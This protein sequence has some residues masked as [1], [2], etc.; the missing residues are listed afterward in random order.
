MHLTYA[1]S[2]FGPGCEGCG[3]VCPQGVSM[4]KLLSV[5]QC[6]DQGEPTS[7]PFGLTTSSGWK[8]WP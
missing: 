8:N 1:A 4:G 6:T 7:S 2:S 5:V 3:S